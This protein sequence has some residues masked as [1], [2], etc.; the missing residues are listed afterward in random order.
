MRGRKS[1]QR[2]AKQPRSIEY[3]KARETSREPRGARHVVSSATECPTLALLARAS[4]HTTHTHTHTHTHT[5]T[6]KSFIRA[7]HS[8]ARHIRGRDTYSGR[9]RPPLVARLGVGSPAQP[10]TRIGAPPPHP[11]TSVRVN[12]VQAECRAPSH[13]VRER[14]VGGRTRRADSARVVVWLAWV[15]C[16]R[17]ASSCAGRRPTPDAAGRRTCVCVFVSLLAGGD[18]QWRRALFSARSGARHACAR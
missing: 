11:T 1:E 13:Y 14:P 4:E 16:R 2:R 12:A 3:R 18:A 5:M 10:A 6:T 7:T 9:V 17:A 8:R 15:M